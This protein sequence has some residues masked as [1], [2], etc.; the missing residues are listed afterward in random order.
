MSENKRSKD[1]QKIDEV[2]D[3]LLKAYR[4]DGKMLEMEII[5]SWEEMMGKAV[6][7]RTEKMYFQHK[8]LHIKLNSSV[9]RDELH[10][11]KQIII[12]RVNQKAGKEMITDIWFE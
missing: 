4:L 6:A 12:Q 3:K 8:V 2:I 11:G 7:L 5:N 1:D 9:M 10:A